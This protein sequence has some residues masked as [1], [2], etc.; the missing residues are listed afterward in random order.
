MGNP[1][2]K[3]EA[4]NTSR[5]HHK[6]EMHKI[7]LHKPDH[8]DSSGTC[9]VSVC[10]CSVLQCVAVCCRV[11]PCDAVCCGVLQCVAAQRDSQ[12]CEKEDCS[13]IRDVFVC[14]CSMLQC[15]PASCS[16][17]ILQRNA[18]HRAVTTRTSQ[19]QG[20]EDPYDASIGHFAQK[21]PIIY[22]FFAKNDRNVIRRAVTTRTSHIVYMMCLCVSVCVCV[23]LCVSVCFTLQRT[24]TRCSNTLTH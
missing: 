16:A 11:L 4:T 9:D 13:G 1:G 5:D 20:G 18:I 7:Q 10:C 19:V 15:V 14:C 21:A 24:T 17:S 3:V 12:D 6:E 2:M 23:C 8:E 22:G